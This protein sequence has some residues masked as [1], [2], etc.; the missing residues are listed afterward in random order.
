VCS[1]D[2]PNTDLEQRLREASRLMNV[3]SEQC[4]F[5]LDLHQ[6]VV[7]LLSTINLAERTH[8]P[9]IASRAYGTL[10]Y[11][12]G[13]GRFHR[14]SRL[15]FD[16]GR[17]GLD[18]DAHVNTAVGMG[19]YHLPF[20]RW[21]E[22]I[23]ALEDGKRRAGA[24]GDTFGTGLCLNVL[25][26]VRHLIGDL[27]E[28]VEAYDDLVANAR[29]RSNAQHEVW[30]LSGA[31]ETLLSQGRLIEASERLRECAAVLP[32]LADRD[33]LSAFRHEGVKAAVL[34]RLEG[35]ATAT[36]AVTEALRLSRL[37]PAPMY[38]TYWAV[39]CMLETAL[40]LWKH[41]GGVR[42]P[43]GLVREAHRVMRRFA[44]VFPI[45]RS[46]RALLRGQERWM[47]G[48]QAA[49]RAEWR[50]ALDLARACQMPP[51]IDRA[52]RA[53]DNPALHGVPLADERLDHT[54]AGT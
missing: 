52:R 41:R 14:L 17:R 22:C 46:R 48:A 3:V 15:Y 30:G 53:L 2:L 19:L 13:L 33:R 43:P 16:R 23:A 29:A 49:A 1:S 45:A 9:E 18:A 26:D 25:G 4:Y 51:E 28:A 34:M 10:G 42:N 40:A 39:S 12:V 7:C 38:A 27:A 5:S 6:M 36:A 20:G 11:V 8:A 44:V 24:V 35:P 32:S 37:T 50:R 21:Q 47:T 54:A 31:A